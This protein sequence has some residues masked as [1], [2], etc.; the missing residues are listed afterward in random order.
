MN[1]LL[2]LCDIIIIYFC[3][4]E[5]FFFF[6]FFPSF[7]NLTENFGLLKYPF[8]QSFHM[9]QGQYEKNYVLTFIDDLWDVIKA[10]F[11]AIVSFFK[12]IFI[13]IYNVFC[14][15]GNIFKYPFKK[16]DPPKEKHVKKKN[17]KNQKINKEKSTPIKKNQYEVGTFFANK[18]YKQNTPNKT[19]DF[20]Y[21][22]DSQRTSRNTS[23]NSNN[24]KNYSNHTQNYAVGFNSKNS[25]K[26]K[27]INNPS[28]DND[29]YYIKQIQEM[30]KSNN[31]SNNNQNEDQQYGTNN[32]NNYDNDQNEDQQSNYNNNY[33]D[34]Q[35]EDPIQ[36]QQLKFNTNPNSNQNQVQNSFQQFSNNN[37]SKY[38]NDFQAQDT[39]NDYQT[40]SFN[41]PNTNNHG[42]N[43]NN[44]HQTQTHYNQP[45][46]TPPSNQPHKPLSKDDKKRQQIGR[47]TMQVTQ[48]GKYSF[49]NQRK[50]QSEVIDIKDKVDYCVY[51]TETI[52]PNQK[53]NITK[54]PDDSPMCRIEVTTES[55]FEALRR[56]KTKLKNPIPET[57][58][59]NFASATQ[60][61]GG[62]LNGRGAQE[63][64]LSRQS[65]LYPAL[66]P[67]TEMYDYNKMKDDPYYSD[68]M[69][70]S[71]NVP[72]FRDDNYN[73]IYP[74]RA[75]VITSPAVNYAELMKRN[76]SG[77][78][79]ENKIEKVMKNR[80]RKIL[81][82]CI[83]RGNRA[84]VLGAFGCGVFKNPPKMI[85]N[86]FNDLLYKEGLGRNLTHV[87]FPIYSKDGSKDGFTYKTFHKILVENHYHK[88]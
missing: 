45:I 8:Q 2:D 14:F 23:F 69:I 25:L 54:L 31:Y 51:H 30:S 18:K 32:N 44:Y 84:I 79:V 78:D 24:N 22:P 1:S 37:Y 81:Q 39:F 50:N 87:V 83:S 20:S 55:S 65:A 52:K 88:F 62:F 56:L 15:I 40:R 59:L 12:F 6:H 57:C 74:F 68:Y 10:F 13:S 48:T 71:P 7:E 46:Y 4:N 43:Y 67:Q 27:S 38:K 75:S 35:D 82:L 11:K 29:N 85:S 72:F 5:D 34:S 21:S 66:L 61:G 64:T 16:E 58:I 53:Y 60:P 76:Q 86:I 73:F 70:Y 49:Y 42:H 41:P 63:E 47:E 28:A 33:D 9:K 36:F 3:Q 77:D 80:C 19:N 26:N 17:N